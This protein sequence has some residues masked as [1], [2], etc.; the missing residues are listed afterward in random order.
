M[1]SAKASRLFLRDCDVAAF[2]TG[3]RSV[4][5]FLRASSAFW[6]R[7]GFPVQLANKPLDHVVRLSAFRH[8]RENLSLGV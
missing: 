8:S 4:R 5:V 3:Y 2:W 1:F 6:T 7:D